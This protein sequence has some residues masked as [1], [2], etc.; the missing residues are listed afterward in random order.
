MAVTIE[1]LK[2]NYVAPDGS[3]VPVI[4]VPHFKLFP[5]EQVALIGSSGSGKTTLLHL[6]AGILAPDRGRFCLML[7]QRSKNPGLKLPAWARHT[8]SNTS[9]RLQPRILFAH[10]PQRTSAPSRKPGAMS[11]EGNTL[12]TFFKPTTCSAGSPQW[13]MC[14]WE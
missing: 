7:L 10:K 2:K 13:K 14:C 1:S 9:R 4:D 3:I 8:T 12:D 11:S 5:G 6:I